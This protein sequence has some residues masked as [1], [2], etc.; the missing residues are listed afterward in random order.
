[1]ECDTKEIAK[2]CKECQLHANIP[3]I[4]CT[5][6]TSITTPI[7]FARWGIDIVG[8]FPVASYDKKFLFVAIDYFTKWAEAEPVKSITQENAI[9]FIFRSMIC[10][11]GVPLQ[12]ITY[13]ETQFTGRSMKKSCK[14]NEI[15]LS[16]TSVYH[17]QINGQIEATNKNLVKILK[18]KIDDNPKE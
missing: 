12:I 15:K 2:N 17:P 4:S 14:D 6:L 13:N 8:P 18:R 10:K 5:E 1:M 16:F 3:K 11:F 9:K 7:P